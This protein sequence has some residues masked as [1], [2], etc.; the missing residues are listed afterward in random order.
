M[1]DPTH[2]SSRTSFSGS[3][4]EHKGLV[5]YSISLF[6][7]PAHLFSVISFSK[8]SQSN[9]FFNAVDLVKFYEITL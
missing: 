6:F 1:K 3:E 5:S 4:G 2:D 7:P 8:T 9:I